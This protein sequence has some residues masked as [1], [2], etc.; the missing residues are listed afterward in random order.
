MCW[1][2]GKAITIEGPI[3][4]SATCDSCGVDVR[5]CR[6]CRFWSPGDWHDC[7]ERQEDEVRDKERAN[8]CDSFQLNPRFREDHPAS[9]PGNKPGK[10]S[11]RSAFDGLFGQ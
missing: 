1:K 4:R 8:F 5:S 2:C 11:A 9:G 10:D 7:A 3:G 6:N